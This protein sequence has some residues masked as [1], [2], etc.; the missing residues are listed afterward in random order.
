MLPARLTDGVVLRL[1]APDDATALAAALVR[2]RT[3]LAPWEPER[4]AEFFTPEGQAERLRTA[5]AAHDAGTAVPL[6]LAADDAVV[7]RVDLVDVV[8][9]AFCNAHLGYWVDGERQGRGIMTAAVGVALRVA[10]DD[11]GLHRVQAATLVHNAGSQ[12]VLA[13]NGFEQIGLAPRYLKIA[14]RWQDHVLFQRI[15]HD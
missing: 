14:G 3:H 10:R 13:T 1:A 7:G 12:R 9:G 8:R 4:P 2:N 15:L 6:V 5:L 11:L